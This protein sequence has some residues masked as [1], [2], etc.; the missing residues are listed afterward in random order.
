MAALLSGIGADGRGKNLYPPIG[1]FLLKE[2][3]S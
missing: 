3:G 2:K 1:T